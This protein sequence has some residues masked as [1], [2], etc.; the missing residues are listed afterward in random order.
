MNRK[1]L[2]NIIASNGLTE[3]NK[4][5]ETRYIAKLDECTKVVIEVA[6]NKIIIK[7]SVYEQP[8][9]NETISSRNPLYNIV[10][11]LLVVE[12]GVC[13]V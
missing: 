8:L 9:I 1:L 10:K 12:G 3:I 7:S 4:L 11:N 6:T 2:G 5:E 13:N